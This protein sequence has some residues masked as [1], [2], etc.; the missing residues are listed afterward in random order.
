[1]KYKTHIITPATL[2][3]IL[4]DGGKETPY[5][6]TAQSPTY[7]RFKAALESGDLEAIPT[8]IDP[9]LRV[10]DQ[11]GSD[12]KI[13]Q[14]TMSIGGE[15]VPK[16]LADEIRKAAQAGVDATGLKAAWQRLKKNPSKHSIKQAFRFIRKN[17][18]H[19]LADGRFILYKGVKATDEPGVYE[20]LH[21]NGDRFFYRLGVMAQEVGGRSVCDSDP[22]AACSRGLHGAP[23]TH[24]YS[25][26]N[27]H[28]II[29]S[30]ICDPED[31][32]GVPYGSDSQKMRL[33]QVLPQSVV[34]APITEAL[35]TTKR[36][37]VIGRVT[38]A[39]VNVMK[40]EN[41]SVTVPLCT[42]RITLPVEFMNLAGFQSDSAVTAFVTD[43]RSRFVAVAVTN[44]NN[45]GGVFAKPV[46]MLS[47]GAFSLRLAVLREAQIGDAKQ[48]VAKVEAPGL[49]HIRPK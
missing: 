17:G 26:Y 14:G 30:L 45:A 5:S 39:I 23:W 6:F 3:V 7:N 27:S 4:S 20:S 1:M 25:Y 31:I 8:I 13:D 11:L 46:K 44:T 15:E 40:R 35:I 47:S 2:V 29:I 21:N 43:K 24:V 22:S 10:A 9:A 33:W 18:V 32:V 34:T 42:D 49:I 36:T 38:K 48:Y 37:G 28:N 12:V 16:E 19:V 41:K